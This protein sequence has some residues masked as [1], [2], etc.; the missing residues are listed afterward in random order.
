VFKEPG[1]TLPCG[2]IIPKNTF[3]LERY[4]GCPFC[5]TP[6]EQGELKLLKQ[7][8]KKKILELWTDEKMNG[9]FKDTLESKTALDATQLD[10]LLL[11]LKELEMPQAE[12]GMKETMMAVIDEYVKQGAIDKAK[13]LF[14]SPT[15]VLRYLWYK[16][17][18]FIQIY[19]PKT[20]IKRIGKNNSGFWQDNSAKSK[21]EAAAKMKL[22]YNRKMCFAV[23]T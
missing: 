5:G 20:I 14:S 4:N 6:F 11:M 13:I 18:G 1:T 17:T 19:E 23:A 2:H 8:S 15:D 21:L 16:H 7:G 22:K 3:P 9:F 10:S 12:I